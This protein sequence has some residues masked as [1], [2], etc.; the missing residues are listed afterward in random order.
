MGQWLRVAA[1]LGLGAAAAGAVDWSALKPKGYVSDFAGVVDSASRNRL[2]A[3]CGEVERTTGAQMALVTVS[4]LSGEPVGM[5]ADALFRAWGIGAKGGN[6]G[7]LLL[8]ATGDRRTRLVVG[9]GLER[10]IPSDMADRVFREMRPALRKKDYGD[11]LMAAAETVGGAIAQ[12]KHV[13]LS[14]RL[15]RQRSDRGTGRDIP[16]CAPAG[17][18]HHARKGEPCD[19]RGDD[20]GLRTG[21][22]K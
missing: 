18:E 22:G 10:V 15:P 1:W 14:E 20:D 17:F 4:S 2:E 11:A 3:Y 9:S 6:Q 12:G 21:N 16:A 13:S 8:V 7:I 5:V 19:V